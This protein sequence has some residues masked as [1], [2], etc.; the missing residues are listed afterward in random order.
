ME[1]KDK[2]MGPDGDI[3]RRAEV[4]CKDGGPKNSIRL[5][6]EAARKQC[7]GAHNSKQQPT[8]NNEYV[9]PGK[10]RRT[11][12]ARHGLQY[13]MTRARNAG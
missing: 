3:W 6:I 8:E 4:A 9:S 12:K 13:K 1:M 11:R 7:R 5:W 10:L 2:R